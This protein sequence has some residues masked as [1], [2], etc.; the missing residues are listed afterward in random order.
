MILPPVA[1]V[2]SFVAFPEEVVAPATVWWREFRLLAV[3]S[4]RD[5]RLMLP[6]DMRLLF[7]DV[8]FV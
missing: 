1:L 2:L 7:N 3:W 5:G 8:L 6:A 4:E